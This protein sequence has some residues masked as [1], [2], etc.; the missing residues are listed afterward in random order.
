[1]KNCQNQGAGSQTLAFH[2]FFESSIPLPNAII[3]TI[4]VYS[5]FEAYSE[6]YRE[7][8]MSIFKVSLNI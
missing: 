2:V 3:K 6:I 8:E 5:I 1:M 4:E 7:K